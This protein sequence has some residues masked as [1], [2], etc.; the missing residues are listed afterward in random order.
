M[1]KHSIQNW[2]ATTSFEI[3]WLDFVPKK[4]E[5]KWLIGNE[6]CKFQEEFSRP[7]PPTSWQ[8][9]SPSNGFEPHFSSTFVFFK[10]I[11]EWSRNWSHP[12]QR[13][14]VAAIPAASVI[15]NHLMPQRLFFSTASNM[16]SLVWGKVSHC[17]SVELSKAG[18]T[19]WY[20]HDHDSTCEILKLSQSLGKGKPT[21]S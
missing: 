4:R 1:F 19:C 16:G 21:S 15:L 10:E 9:A 18:K 13:V 14:D 6:T 3:F 5:L 11:Q 17:S 20:F 12:R 2:S 7:G 8:G